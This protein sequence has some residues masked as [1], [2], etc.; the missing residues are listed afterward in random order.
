MVYHNIYKSFLPSYALHCK[1]MYMVYVLLCC[2]HT[3]YSGFPLRAHT[4]CLTT[5]SKF[6][7]MNVLHGALRTLTYP[8]PYGSLSHP[9]L[10]WLYVFSSFPP[11]PP[12]PPRPPLQQLLPLLSKPF[13]LNLRYL[14][15]GIYGSG[16]IYWMTFPWPVGNCFCGKFSLEI[17]DVFFQGQAL[18]WPYLR[19]G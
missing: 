18:F 5:L 6:W 11:R 2:G 19:N 17:L 4:N 9:G 3:C 14:A 7:Y 8:T 15:Q 12:P 10:G 1:I 13:E 16:E